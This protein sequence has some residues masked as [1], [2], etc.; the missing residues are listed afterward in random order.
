M[1][2][3]FEFSRGGSFGENILELVEGLLR[4]SEVVLEAFTLV[5]FEFE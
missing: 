4:L 3:F 5:F 2:E 1:N